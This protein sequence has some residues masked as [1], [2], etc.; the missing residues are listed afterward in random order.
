[1]DSTVECVFILYSTYPAIHLDSLLVSVTV[2]L[3]PISPS[4]GDVC[5]IMYI[6]SVFSIKFMPFI[7]HALVVSMQKSEPPVS[8][9]AFYSI[10]SYCELYLMFFLFPSYL[11]FFLAGFSSRIYFSV[12]KHWQCLKAVFTV[13]LGKLL[14][15]REWQRPGMLR[16][17]L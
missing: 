5:V 3:N 14:L 17:I 6:V 9:P 16:K 4:L 12:R 7:T 8:F 2:I 1:M 11:C 10:I 13:T 15:T